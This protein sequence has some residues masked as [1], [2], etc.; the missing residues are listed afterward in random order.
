VPPSDPE[1]LARS[2]DR[3]VADPDL[4]KRLGQAGSVRVR[5]NFT[6][7]RMIESTMQVYEKMLNETGRE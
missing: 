4:C 2:I 5:E 7:K 1:A 6:E 3:L